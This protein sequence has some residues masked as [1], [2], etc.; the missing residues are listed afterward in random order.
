MK[1]SQEDPK[2]ENHT[3]ELDLSGIDLNSIDSL[4][5]TVLGSIIRELNEESNEKGHARHSSHSSY[6]AHGTATW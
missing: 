4:E 5:E 3:I 1:K 2:Q 6:T